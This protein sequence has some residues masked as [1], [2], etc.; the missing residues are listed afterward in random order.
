MNADL[1]PAP[2]AAHLP[3]RRRRHAGPALPRRHAPGLRARPRRRRAARAPVLRLRAERHHHAGLEARGGGERLRVHAHPEAPRAL[4]R[5][6]PRPERPRPQQR[7]RARRRARRPRARRRLLPDRRPPEEDRG[8]RH[9]ER[10]LRRPDRGP[11]PG[12]RRRGCP[13]W[14]WAARSRAP[15]ATATP[16]TAARTRTASPGAPPPRRMPPE[17]NPRLVFERLFGDA[18]NADPAARARRARERTSILDVV[19]ERSRELMGQLGAARPAQAGRV[20]IRGARDRAADPARGDG[21]AR[22]WCRPIEKPSGIPETFAEYLKL[23]YEL[24]VIA[25]QADLTRV[26]TLMVGRE[27][28][29]QSYPEIGVP[30]PHHPLTHH[31]N[32]PEW[33]EKVTRINVHHVELFAHFVSRLKA[34][35]GR[36][37]HAPRSLDGGLRQRDRAT[38]TSTRTRACPCS[39]PAG[40]GAPSRAGATSPTRSRRPHEP[41]PDPARS[42]GRSPGDDRRQHRADRAPVGRLAVTAAAA[43]RTPRGPWPPAPPG[44]CGDRPGR[45]G[46]E[47]GPW[48]APGARLPRER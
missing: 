5:G 30:D 27:G 37:R 31:Q 24:Q 25:F 35:P 14:S 10:R 9:P 22:R 23:M 38:A 17:T 28:S 33:V 4:P 36:R 34:T 19:A 15:S 13:R 29:L 44:P 20:P 47:P 21:H 40:A 26:A 48:T 11:G 43:G 12:R 8:R 3:A 46:S 1:P 16:A 41:V 6:P 42:H 2:P 39:W 18:D 32:N 7:E 45:G